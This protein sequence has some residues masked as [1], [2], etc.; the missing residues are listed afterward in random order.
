MFNAMS[1]ENT[2]YRRS[3]QRKRN[4]YAKVLRQERK[5]LPKVINPKKQEYKRIRLNPN[6]YEREED[7]QETI[8]EN[9]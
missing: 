8:G 6:D 1:D 5:F 9:P 3:Q 4:I 2:R 7:E